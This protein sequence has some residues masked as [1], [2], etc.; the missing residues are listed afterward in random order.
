MTPTRKGVET[1]CPYCRTCSTALKSFFI[2]AST[3]QKRSNHKRRISF[4]VSIESIQAPAATK[5]VTMSAVP[6]LLRSAAIG[7]SLVNPAATCNVR[8]S[9]VSAFVNSRGFHASSPGQAVKTY[10]DIAYTPKNG[11]GLLHPRCASIFIAIPCW[12]KHV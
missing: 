3:H 2:W 1:L 10:F 6:R 11:G 5:T 8:R 12:K 7:R 9:A 4:P